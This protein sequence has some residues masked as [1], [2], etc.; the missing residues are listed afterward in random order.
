MSG[1]SDALVLDVDVSI[2][3]NEGCPKKLCVAG[4]A[5]DEGGEKAQAVAFC[6][7]PDEDSSVVGIEGANEG[8]WTSRVDSGEGHGDAVSDERGDW[9]GDESSSG[10]NSG[11]FMLAA[12]T[13]VG[14][15]A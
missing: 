14:F 10:R 4:V 5:I 1:Y 6:S 12:L 8:S 9:N 15:A 7:D 3:R 13:A 2:V 11:S